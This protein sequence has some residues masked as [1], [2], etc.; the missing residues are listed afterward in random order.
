MRRTK[1][2]L[3]VSGVWLLA[4]VLAG[5]ALAILGFN[6]R[7]LGLAAVL[8]LVATGIGFWLARRADHKA[9]VRLALLAQA[10]GVKPDEGRS[11]EAI[12]NALAQRL[13]RTG[14]FKSAFRLLQQPAAI[15]TIGGEILV[16]SQGLM[17]LEPSAVE[18]QSLDTLFDARVLAGGGGVAEEELVALGDRRF[19]MHRK[20]IGT[21]RMVLE[22]EPAGHFVGDDDLDAFAEALAGGQTGF[23]FDA[24]AARQSPVLRVMNDSLEIFDAASHGIDQLC[25]GAVLEPAILESNSGFGPQLRT[26]HDAVWTLATERDEEAAAREA[27]EGKLGAIARAIDGYRT[28]ATRMGELA[29]ATQSGIAVASKAVKTGRAKMTAALQLEREAKALAVNAATAARRTH[30]AAGGVDLASG[31]IDKMVAAIEDVSFRTNL[32]ALNAAVEAA[33]AGEQGAGFGV[34]AEEVRTLAQTTTRTARDIRLLVGHSRAQ[35]G[36]GLSEA[37]DLEKIIAGLEANL[38]NLSNESHMIAGAL[39]EG[40]GALGQID[41]QVGAVSE[42][43][44]RA[45]LLPARKQ[46]PA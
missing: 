24:K 41:A 6:S 17:A 21:T 3:I 12:V 19:I 18:G 39:D 42:E 14:H 2:A 36:I 37:G 7:S 25:A 45:L 5:F 11:I 20:L 31:E 33:R 1:L 32:L 40:S 44:K 15:A 26:L 22:L 10:V 23:R 16:A 38:R 27:M 29:S 4:G 43:A 46:R 28:A 8:V 35:A 34:V 30:E 9:D 13:E